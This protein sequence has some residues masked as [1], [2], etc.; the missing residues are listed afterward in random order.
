MSTLEIFGMIA[1][2]YLGICLLLYFTQELFLFHPEKLISNFEYKFDNVFD[3]VYIPT[4]DGAI[5]NGLLFKTKDSKGVVFYFKGNTRSIKGWGK[6]SR[7]FISKGYDFFV[8]DYR[9]FGKSKGKR[10]ERNFH[11]D[12]DAA[13]QYLVN[14]HYK[15]EQIIIYGRSIG[16]GFATRSASR[17]NPKALI[18]DSPYY[19]LYHLVKRFFPLFPVMSIFKY[20]VRTD[21]F[22]KGVK[23]PIY[24]IHG[25]KDRLI[26]YRHALLLT[27]LNP[28]AHL[29]RFKEGN[30]NNLPK[31]SEYHNVVYEIL[32]DSFV[33]SND[34]E[35]IL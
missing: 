2:V 13:Y 26:P 3:E 10:S 14:N 27:K 31:F 30:H 33:P 17:N 1:L 19:S 12:C 7:D 21:I 15:E 4:S 34:F 20:H 24:I 28:R 6:F 35:E 8:F 22:I 9:G 23:C 11:K 32:N 16:S 5:L 29:I 25:V 18:L